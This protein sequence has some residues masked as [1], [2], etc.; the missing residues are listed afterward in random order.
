MIVLIVLPK[1]VSSN[2][3]AWIKSI[4]ENK[5]EALI[6]RNWISFGRSLV[7]VFPIPFPQH[8]IK[9]DRCHQW[10]TR[11]DSQPRL[12]FFSLEICFYFWK[13]GTDERTTC[14]KTIITTSSECG[15]AEW[16]KNFE[17][18]LTTMLLNTN[19]DMVEKKVGSKPARTYDHSEFIFLKISTTFPILLFYLSYL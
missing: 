16:I 3:S 8:K 14:E 6:T 13:V 5:A 17:A 1:Y 12:K 4:F 18:P 11:P 9:Q 10:S 15:L 2:L 7:I 19:R